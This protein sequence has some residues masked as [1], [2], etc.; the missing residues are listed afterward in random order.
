V[1][2]SWLSRSERSERIQNLSRDVLATILE[3]DPA[4]FYRR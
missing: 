4:E 1:I 2:E 3:V